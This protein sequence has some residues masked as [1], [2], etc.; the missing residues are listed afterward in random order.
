MK[1]PRSN[2]AAKTQAATHN[3]R[4]QKTG[5]LGTVPRVASQSAQRLS[6]TE[7]TGTQ[8]SHACTLP[9]L[10]LFDGKRTHK[11]ATDLPQRAPRTHFRH[12]R[13]EMQQTAMAWLTSHAKKARR[14]QRIRHDS[15][16]DRQSLR[17]KHLHFWSNTPRRDPECTRDVWHGKNG[18]AAKPCVYTPA[19]TVRAGAPHVLLSMRVDGAYAATSPNA[20]S[21]LAQTSSV[22]AASVVGAACFESFISCVSSVD[23]FD[24]RSASASRR[25]GFFSSAPT[26]TL[27]GL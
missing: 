10:R 5:V 11:S 16:C 27:L 13:R 22:R 8:P 3:A 24:S 18:D 7:R 20:C 21:A 25:P 12:T 19:F 4:G 6:R 17:A 1:N 15:G 9:Y 2:E 23:V 26:G 14:W